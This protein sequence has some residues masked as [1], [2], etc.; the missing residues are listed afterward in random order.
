METINDR[1][2]AVVKKTGLTK[3]AFAKKIN[4]SQSFVSNI[5]VGNS[6]PS[7]RT[8]VDICKTFDVN[9]EWLRTGT[10]D[11][12]AAGS[13]KEAEIAAIMRSI[14]GDKDPEFCRRF[15]AALARLD[16]SGWELVEKMVLK[17]A[18]EEKAS[19]NGGIDPA[20][21]AA[22]DDGS[23]EA[24]E[25]LYRSSSGYVANADSSVLNTT[26][27]VKSGGKPA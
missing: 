13:G 17:L 19:A 20:V 4:L 1:I 24:A 14:M 3:T 5:C 23:T 10:G 22:P 7:E 18:G 26:E 9:E 25:T 6:S 27:D 21:A 15:S 12:F 2:A 8:I 11:M 16:E